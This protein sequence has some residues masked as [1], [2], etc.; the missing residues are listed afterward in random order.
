M[1]LKVVEHR[2]DPV[3]YKDDFPEKLKSFPNIGSLWPA[4]NRCLDLVTASTLK[5]LSRR[6]LLYQEVN[7][8]T[9]FVHASVTSKSNIDIRWDFKLMLKR[10]IAQDI[11]W[12]SWMIEH[13]EN[14]VRSKRDFQTFT[15]LMHGLKFHAIGRSPWFWCLMYRLTDWRFVVPYCYCFWVGNSVLQLLWNQCIQCIYLYFAAVLYNSHNLWC[16]N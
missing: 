12:M 8:Q 3:L 11:K 13:T 9:E 14:L 6:R 4:C 7:I 16:S 15:I 2:A 1:P 10:R 5:D